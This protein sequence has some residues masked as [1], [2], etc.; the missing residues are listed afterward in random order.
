MKKRTI[1][2]GV[3]TCCILCSITL[4]VTSYRFIDAEITPKW[5]GLMLCIGIMGLV[6]SI[7]GNKISFTDFLSKY[8]FG[9]IIVFAL[10][11]S[12]Q[13]I[14]Q[15]VGTFPYSSN[16]FAVTGSFD[17]PAGYAAALTCSFPFCFL[18]FRNK[19]LYIRYAAIL[20]AVLMMIVVILS[21]SRAGI[22]SIA[23]VI[24]AWLFF[25]PLKRLYKLKFIF[26]IAIVVLTFVLYFIK[27]DSADGRL[28]IWRCTLDMVTDKPVFGHGVGSFNAKYMLY[29][30]A[31]FNDYPNSRYAQLADNVQ[32]PFNEYLFILAEYGIAGLGVVVLVGLL[33][34]CI[35]RRN[36][37]YEKL[38]ALMSLVAL[39]VFSLFSYP[40]KY[41]FTWVILLFNIAIICKVKIR[42]S[43][44][45]RITVFL[46][47]VGLLTYTFM[48]TQAEIKWRRMTHLSLTGKTN[49]VLPEYEKLYRILG[50]NG[51]FLYNH[52]AE[53]HKAKEFERS[54]AVFECCLRHYN[55]MDI[56]MM[57]ASN[58]KELGKYTE[59]EKHLKTAAAMCPARFMPLYE[60]VKLYQVT[61]RSDEAM[62][63]AKKIID[64][65]VKIPS[66]T[67][68]EI[69]NEMKRF[70]E[71]K[72]TSHDL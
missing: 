7:Q 40:F 63:L 21:G 50:R 59:A 36:H 41:P 4:F 49:Q 3:L 17:N 44:L 55:D 56:Q 2:F 66:S 64:K 34:V 35:Y 58:Y 47:S 65:D 57:L 13:G 52:A 29:Q 1:I 69:V 8:L 16:K 71:T 24:L 51:L 26:F 10:V 62:V 14:L 54:V 18:F 20:A 32:H 42:K 5:L 12:I 6:W 30:A 67:V 33:L 68:I 61:G 60:L 45:M 70:L 31:Y 46:L 11:L 48:V 19:T 72:E 27:K 25:Q 9:T 53:L 37:D 22:L 28:L 15:Y 43:Y 38:I 23:V 39:S